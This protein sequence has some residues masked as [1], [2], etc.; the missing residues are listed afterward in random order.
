MRIDRPISLAFACFSAC[1]GTMAMSDQDGGRGRDAGRTRDAGVL[2]DG[3]IP[4]DPD[5]GTSDRDASTPPPGGD[6]DPLPAARGTVMRVGPSDA[7]DLPDLVRSAASGTTIL[8]EDGT[9]RMGGD[10]ASRRLQFTTDG[11]TLRSASGDPEAVIIDGEYMTN[12]IVAISASDVTIAELTITH[13]VDHAIHATAPAGGP[14]T[15]GTTIYRVRLVDNGEQ[16]VKVNSNGGGAYADE[17]TL[18]CSHFELTDAGRPHV[19]RAVGGCYTGGIDTHGGR[20][21]VVRDNRFV[22]LYCAGEGL[23]EH[24]IHFWSGSRDTL[25]ERNVI[26]DCARGIGF[27]LVESGDDRTY[28]DDPYPSVGY[29]GHYDGIIRN[30]AIYAA[31]PWF[32]S[33]VELAQARGTRV[34]HNTVYSTDSATGF[35]SS[36]DYRFSN[37]DVDVRNNIAVRITARDG[38]SG[39]VASNSEGADGSWFVDAASGDLHLAEGAA[40]AID[41]GEV[42][43]EAGTD[44]DGDPH[45][46]G[47][48]DLGADER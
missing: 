41:R 26:V 31:I 27:G 40:G 20:G 32:D 28:A 21:W 33:G 42:I 39:T 15:T 19:E 8:L 24:A 46:R 13:A 36:I 3:H 38:A 45:D 48:P 1:T 9:Y 14:T 18:A 17:G 30:N 44:L 4:P 10:E 29:I 2:E 23:A 5:G 12:E 11:V 16:F 47:A 25:V 35:F 7:A 43:A 34:Y 22:D 6:C 37:T